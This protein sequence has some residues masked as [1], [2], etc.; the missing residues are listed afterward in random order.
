M[1]AFLFTLCL[2]GSAFLHAQDTVLRFPVP[3][4]AD[5]VSARLVTP[6]SGGASC[7][8]LDMGQQ[9]QYILLDSQCQVLHQFTEK[10]DPA[11]NMFFLD[12]ACRLGTAV[13]G[14]VYHHYFTIQSPRRE[15]T[16]Y[17]KVI[18][19]SSHTTEEVPILNPAQSSIRMGF[20]LDSEG[21]PYL[22]S[23]SRYGHALYFERQGPGG[24]ILLDSIVLDKIKQ[25]ALAMGY[26]HYVPEGSAQ[27]LDLNA[28]ATLAFTRGRQLVLVAQHRNTDPWFMIV[29]LETFQAHIKALSALAAF[30]DMDTTQPFSIS[31]SILGDRFFVLKTQKAQTDVGIFQIP[32]LDMLGDVALNETNA[33]SLSQ[34]P[35]Q[36]NSWQSGKHDII[37]DYSA[38]QFYQDLVASRAGLAAGYD[39]DGRY[40]LTFGYVYDPWSRYDDQGNPFFYLG[41]LGLSDDRAPMPDR[42]FDPLVFGV[43][44]K[45]AAGWDPQTTD[46]HHPLYPGKMYFHSGFAKVTLDPQSL[47]PVRAAA[48][49]D[50]EENLWN[51]VSP[52]S[53]T[54]SPVQHF[55]ICGHS[56]A[57]AFNKATRIYAIWEIPE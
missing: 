46:R 32:S 45:H 3:D 10:G 42:D 53:K 52:E 50:A 41:H 34:T 19:F 54:R 20:F 1:K 24:D 4:A 23:S 35:I 6:A 21:K 33:S 38:K 39:K 29:D 30:N 49:A 48:P 40:V 26:V 11:S 9:Q 37:N 47:E 5:I 28:G 57:G 44:P 43:H 27:R 25:P 51:V 12:R 31:A 17:D 14:N 55:R 2:L 18:D 36:Y 22:L 13:R 7:L 15:E 8:A 56:Y 16:L